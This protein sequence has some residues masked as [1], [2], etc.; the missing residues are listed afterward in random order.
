MKENRN[1]KKH[2]LEKNGAR[3]FK[4]TQLF[5]SCRDRRSLFPENPRPPPG[6]DSC[7]SGQVFRGLAPSSRTTLEG[8]A[9]ESGALL[10]FLGVS[11]PL[12]HDSGEKSRGPTF[13][14]RA[15]GRCFCK[16]ARISKWAKLAK[17][18]Q[19][20]KIPFF[21][22]WN[23]PATLWIDQEHRKRLSGEF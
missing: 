19:N 18:D 7:V 4:V 14:R 20:L 10:R 22:S 6:L 23:I 17:I 2:G 13:F 16:F 9:A 12:L 15:P 5:F 1:S 11:R 8:G 3:I 21:L